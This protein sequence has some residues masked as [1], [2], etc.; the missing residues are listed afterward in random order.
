M[1][2]NAVA[3]RTAIIEAMEAAGSFAHGYFEG[4]PRQA[5]SAKALQGEYVFDVVLSPARRSPFSNVIAGNSRRLLTLDVRI[6]IVAR[7]P[8]PAQGSSRRAVLAAVEAEC[9]V[10]AR[11]LSQPGALSFTSDDTATGVIGG[12]LTDRDGRGEASY[13]EVRQEGAL[14]TL[15]FELLGALIVLCLSDVPANVL[16]WRGDPLTWRGE[17][18]TWR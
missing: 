11:A 13:R 12:V 8:T 9:G 3:V 17:Y 4:Q 1:S 2:I 16:T 7:L 10:A 5:T 14:N 6:P 18:L 15:R